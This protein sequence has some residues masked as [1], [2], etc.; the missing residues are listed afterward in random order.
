MFASSTMAE[1]LARAVVGAAALIA[2]I[3]YSVDCP[4]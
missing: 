3:I 1:H 2:G 4:S